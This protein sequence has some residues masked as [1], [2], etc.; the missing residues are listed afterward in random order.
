MK[1]TYKRRAGPVRGDF[2]FN[3]PNQELYSGKEKTER[4]E[5]RDHF[6]HAYHKGMAALGHTFTGDFISK[7]IEFI[8]KYYTDI[9]GITKP[10]DL[11]TKAVTMVIINPEDKRKVNLVSFIPSIGILTH[12]RRGDLLTIRHALKSIDTNDLVVSGFEG[13]PN[14]ALV[15]LIKNIKSR[16]MLFD[17]EYNNNP[18]EFIRSELEFRQS[19][20]L[21]RMLN[22]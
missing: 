1:E 2:I 9:K 19:V 18:R 17:F 5:I 6:L 3:I 15:D 11:P 22:R 8:I 21:D 16:L 7:F 4:D 10:K 13:E 14:P 20:F 12:A